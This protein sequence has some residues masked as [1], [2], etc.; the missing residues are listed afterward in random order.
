MDFYKENKMNSFK[1]ARMSILLSLLIA[2]VCPSTGFARLDNFYKRMSRRHDRHI[3]R[4]ERKKEKVLQMI[5]PYDIINS[6]II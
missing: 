2:G 3:K 1:R 5:I 6:N 4:I